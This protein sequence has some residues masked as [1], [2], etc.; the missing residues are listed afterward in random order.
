MRSRTTGFIAGLGVVTVIAIAIAVA[1]SVGRPAGPVAASATPTATAAPTP[2]ATATP[3]AAPTSAP[4]P[5]R[6][7]TATPAPGAGTVSGP[8][9]DMTFQARDTPIVPPR[10]A[11]QF[12]Q[13]SLY[14]I[15]PTN[16]GGHVWRLRFFLQ[17]NA[18]ANA[19]IPLDV[20]VT[21]PQG[22][23]T[24]RRYDMGPPSSDDIRIVT[25]PV[26]LPPCEPGPAPGVNARG[27]IVMGVHT[28]RVTNGT[29]TFTWRDIR[30]PEG[31]RATEVWTVTLTCTPVT[32]GSTET[33]CR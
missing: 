24:V 12:L 2:T 28:S 16:D 7:A 9:R 6:A 17:D 10:R 20:S 26:T 23:L 29:Y 27:D 22:P 13:I 8:C 32:A 19:V 30:L 18:P 1:V 15:G 3:T 14:A 21:G 4:S 5:T 11:G 31:T 25:E 33:A